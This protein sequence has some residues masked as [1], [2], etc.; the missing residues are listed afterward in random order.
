M[1]RYNERLGAVF[2]RQVETGEEPADASGSQ[3][4]EPHHFPEALRSRPVAI[5][6]S[7]IVVFFSATGLVLYFKPFSDTPPVGEPGLD[8]FAAGP[9]E[10]YEP[11]TITH[12]ENEK[13]FLIRT[14]DG[15]FL[16]LYDLAPAS[17]SLVESGDL[18]ALTCRLIVRDDDEMS[19]WL[20]NTGSIPGFSSRGL[21][22]E[23]HDAAWDVRGRFVYGALDH[24]LDRFPVETNGEIVRVNLGHRRCMNEVSEATPC[25]PTQ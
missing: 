1:D 25:I 17:Q 10:I 16:A 5:M 6:L 12:F 7:I 13:F 21:Y 8:V 3:R 2:M 19:G 20:G 23:C 18:E 11:G 14:L 24:E 22:D 4:P 9:Y 15:A